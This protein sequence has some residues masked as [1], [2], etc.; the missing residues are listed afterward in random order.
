MSIIAHPLFLVLV[1]SLAIDRVDISAWTL[2][3]APRGIPWLML[4]L[5]SSLSSHSWMSKLLGLQARFF[6]L[7]PCIET[8]DMGISPALSHAQFVENLD[9]SS[10]RHLTTRLG[11]DL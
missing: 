11:D 6:G 9:G 5:C 1:R 7:S 8:H 10:V 2:G 4:W 3:Q